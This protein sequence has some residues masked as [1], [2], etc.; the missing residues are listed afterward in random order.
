MKARRQT[1]ETCPAK[2]DAVGM[3]VMV[4]RQWL[5]IDMWNGIERSVKYLF[6]VVFMDLDRPVICIK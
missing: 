6:K 2:N 4:R 1:D 5:E 3:I